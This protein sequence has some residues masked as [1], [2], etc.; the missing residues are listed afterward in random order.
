[1]A[2]F[3]AASADSHVETLLN[4]LEAKFKT[5]LQ[6]FR[7]LD[8]SNNGYVTADDFAVRY[9][10]MGFEL[11]QADAQRVVEEAD[12]PTTEAPTTAGTALAPYD[13]GVRESSSRST[14]RHKPQTREGFT[15]W[16]PMS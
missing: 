1:M 11:S 15:T 5:K 8:E 10:R 9:R 6:A 4:K 3:V 14:G 16:F 13:I 2:F 7:Y 12:P